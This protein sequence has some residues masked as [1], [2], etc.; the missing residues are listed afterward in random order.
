MI[1]LRLSAASSFSSASMENSIVSDYESAPA[2]LPIGQYCAAM[3]SE[4]HEAD[5]VALGVVRRAG[6]SQPG[7]Q[8]HLIRPSSRPQ[9]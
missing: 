7:D 9:P 1:G 6:I 5:I 4:R 8:P 2:T 3:R